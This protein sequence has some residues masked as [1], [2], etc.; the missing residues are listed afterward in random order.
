MKLPKTQKELQELIDK[1]TYEA[2][3]IQALRMRNEVFA[4]A[5]M[6]QEEFT[7]TYLGDMGAYERRLAKREG[8]S[9]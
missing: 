6:D 4:L 1:E 7:R 8:I 3:T 2:L 5:G 9:I